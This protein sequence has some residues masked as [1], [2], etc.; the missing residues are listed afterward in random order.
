MRYMMIV[1]KTICK[2]AEAN[3]RVVRPAW[4]ERE[5]L[6]DPDVNKLITRN[7]IRAIFKELKEDGLLVYSG[8]FYIWQE[9]H[10]FNYYGQD[11]VNTKT[12][13]P[14]NI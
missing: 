5:L 1:L 6:N 11:I 9:V 4:V 8:S 2:I 10:W 7:K 12:R 14:K 13:H 3:G